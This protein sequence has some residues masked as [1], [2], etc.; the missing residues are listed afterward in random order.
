MS[1]LSTGVGVVLRT[2][3]LISLSFSMGKLSPTPLVRLP[4]RSDEEKRL[5]SSLSSIEVLPE[6]LAEHSP[7]VAALVKTGFCLPPTTASAG[8]RVLPVITL[9]LGAEFNLRQGRG[10][11]VLRYE[12][13]TLSIRRFGRACG[14]GKFTSYIT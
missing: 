1:E 3:Q 12:L 11:D 8:K 6:S 5:S 14:A 13:R 4:S 7:I 9:P 10:R 2:P